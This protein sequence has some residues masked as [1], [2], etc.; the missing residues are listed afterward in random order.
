ME[1]GVLMI[2]PINSE[3]RPK[4]NQLIAEEWG[5]PMIISKGISHDTSNAD[6]FVSVT[7]GELTG[8][9]LYC[10]NDGQC[11]ILVLQS[12]LENQG[13]GSS[14]TRAVINTAKSSHCGRV[15]LITT[16]QEC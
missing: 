16:N 6:G 12:I 7:D 3:L 13:I 5:G 8:Y 10:M 2:V 15:W 9:V 1:W 4:I 11:E 14:L